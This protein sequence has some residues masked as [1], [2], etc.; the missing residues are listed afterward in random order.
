MPARTPAS[1]IAVHRPFQASRYADGVPR[2][3]IDEDCKCSTARSL[4]VLG[5][6]WTMLIVR[7]ALEGTTRFADFQS[8]L[9]LG[10]DMLS[11]RL[12]TLVDYGVMTRESYQEPGQRARPEYHLTSA[13][14]DLHVV[15]G[16]LSDWGDHHLPRAAGP[17]RTREARRTGRTVHAAFIDQLGYEVPG[18]DVAIIPTGN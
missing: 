18:D 11:D 14:R 17:T 10:P 13:G 3:D 5:E 8:H 16:A 12:A 1:H 15:I 9:G 7:E 2:K 6:K 4:T